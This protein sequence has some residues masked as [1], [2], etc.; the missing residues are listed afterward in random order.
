MIEKSVV[1]KY[2][3]FGGEDLLLFELKQDL[4]GKKIKFS[5]KNMDIMKNMMNKI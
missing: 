5:H 2:I 1:K 4:Q 3:S